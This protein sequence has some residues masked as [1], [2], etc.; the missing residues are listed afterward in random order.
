MVTSVGAAAA[1]PSRISPKVTTEDSTTSFALKLA[2][3]LQ[4]FIYKSGEDSHLQFDIQAVQGQ[5]PGTRQFVVTVK[6]GDVVSTGRSSLSTTPSSAS[7]PVAIASTATSPTTAA[8][9]EAAKSE[10]VYSLMGI[11]RPPASSSSTVTASTSSG[12]APTGARLANGKP[13]TNEYEAYWAAQPAVVQQ[14]MDMPDSA[15]GELAKNLADQGY[16]IDVPIMLWGWDPLATMTVRKN[17]GFTW[18]PSANMDPVAV[19][20]GLTFP[21]KPS[22][23]ADNAPEGSIPVSTDWAKGFE[24]TSP[25]MRFEQVS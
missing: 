24:H 14:L 9:T 5:D 23:D 4:E 18:V 1:V 2:G 20:P 10:P 11:P 22:Y 13:V 6:D 3:V 12:A 16:K 25:W 19:G 8:R 17:Q 15:K 7:T 21:G